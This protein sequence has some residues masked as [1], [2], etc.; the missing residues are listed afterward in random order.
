MGLV[1]S[2]QHN[3]EEEMKDNLNESQHADLGM[4]K[5]L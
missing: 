3:V 4:V 2:Q 1:L 5:A